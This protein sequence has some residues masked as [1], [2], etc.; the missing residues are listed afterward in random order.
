MVKWGSTEARI[1]TNPVRRSPGQCLSNISC[2]FVTEEL[3]ILI[4]NTVGRCLVFMC[5][6]VCVCVSCVNARMCLCV[7]VGASY[8]LS[9]V[10]ACVRVCVFI[11]AG[12]GVRFVL[13]SNEHFQ[14]AAIRQG[15][16]LEV[17]QKFRERSVH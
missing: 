9:C 10:R 7:C 4:G 2:P 6:N 1:A 8:L 11:C 15:N 12:V 5:V 13:R 3:S 14:G 17:L 16:L